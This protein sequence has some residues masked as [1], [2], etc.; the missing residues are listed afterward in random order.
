MPVVSNTS[1]LLNLAI[2]NRLYLIHEQFSNIFIPPAV[3]AELRVDEKLPG[4]EILSDAIKSGWIQL[5]ELKNHAMVE[6]LCRD[7][8]RGEAEAIVL[9]LELKSKWLLLDERDARKI[10]KSLGLHVTG[11]L[12]ILLRA[13]KDQKLSS[14]EPVIGKLITQCGFRI[15]D[16]LKAEILAESSKISHVLSGTSKR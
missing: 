1:P 14:I 3:L 12:G 4:S 6:I 13:V 15:S 8:D 7:L 9:A 2:I 5:K 11:I 10:G 16:N